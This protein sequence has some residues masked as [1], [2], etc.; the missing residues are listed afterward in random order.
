MES[1]V[2]LDSGYFTCMVENK[3]CSIQ[4]MYMLHL[5]ETASHPEGG[6]GQ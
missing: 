1:V 4:Q 2:P 3:F 5:L 6:A